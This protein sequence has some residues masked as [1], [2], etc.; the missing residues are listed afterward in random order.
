MLTSRSRIAALGAAIVAPVAFSA[1]AYATPDDASNSQNSMAEVVVTTQRLNEARASIQTQ[2]GASTYTIDSEAIQTIPQADNTLLN[3]V[4]LRAPGVAQ[5]S[6][7]QLHVRGEHNGLQF[8]LNG[9]ILPEGISV[10]GQTLDTRLIDKMTLITGALP[11]EFGLRTA[12]IVDLTT[13]NGVLEPHGNVSLYGGSHN[14]IEPSIFHGGSTGNFSYFV[15]ADFMR[16]KLGIESPDGSSNPLHDWTKQYHGMGYFEYILDP[17][18]RISAVLGTSHD[19]FQIPDRYGAPT[20]G[21]TLLNPTTGQD[22]TD[23]PGSSAALNENQTEIT[24]Y[25]VVSYQ[26][27]HEQ[28]DIQTS[29]SAR[30][31][32]LTYF[33]DYYGDI[34]YQGVGQYA[35]KRDIAFGWQTDAAYHLNAAHTI[36][37]GV[38]L[39]HDKATNRTTSGVLPETCSGLGTPD[40]PYTCAQDPTMAGFDVPFNVIDNS[41]ES[42]MIESVYLQD[43]WKILEPLT[44][45]YG[46]RFDHFNAFTS[47]HQVSPRVNFVWK[48][49]EGMTAHAGY[50]RYFS[51]PPFELVGGRTISKFLNTSNAPP[52]ILIADPPL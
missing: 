1:A 45:N 21:L 29:L 10:F 42:Q 5:D 2:T 20:L 30:Y 16:N 15:T 25:A 19:Q 40:S 48:P 50:S 6:F 32:S 12:G 7:G 4:I 13:K 11:A 33:P 37:A 28:F 24:H 44:V 8:R 17:E 3:Q 36:R 34:L 18:S 22:E 51:P 23:I 26:H 14:T 35:F 39:Q 52:G 38:F 27:S 46:L 43:E 47:G 41:D 9:I 31:S 49:L